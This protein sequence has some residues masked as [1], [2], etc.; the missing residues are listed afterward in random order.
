MD[1]VTGIILAYI[2]AYFGLD[3]FFR[4]RGYRG[5]INDHFDGKTF[6]NIGGKG[7]MR[8]GGF[9]KMLR[10]MF[11]R[12]K[13]DWAWKENAASAKP[14][15][16]IAESELIVT[17][18]NHATVLIQIKGVNILTDPIWSKRTS[19][20]P[21]IGPKR[22]RAPG[23][24]FEDLPPIDLVILSH[25]HYDHLD[26]ATL[27]RLLKR[28]DPRIVCGLGNS[29][30][31]ARHGVCGAVDLDWWQF[32]E[33][34][35]GIVVRCV[36][37]QHFSSRAISDRNKTLWA[38]F[39]VETGHGDIYFAGDTGYGPFLEEIKKRYQGFRLGLIPIGAYLPPFIMSHVHASPEEAYRLAGELNVRTMV[40]IHYGT[41]RLADDRQ[42]QPLLDLK[43]AMERENGVSVEILEN[44]ATIAVPK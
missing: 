33:L 24:A 38:G 27:R 34:E 10:W 40:P 21:G 1:A 12:P 41:F 11:T 15:E 22:Y 9:G 44:G 43:D 23:I 19:P 36:P 17:F 20:V 39:V 37:A 30:Y 16:R 28:H 13:S 5:P 14:K 32:I 7:E 18:V 35:P 3:R 6:Q 2:A 8:R 29:D 42:D 25:N 4:V 31:L 26:L